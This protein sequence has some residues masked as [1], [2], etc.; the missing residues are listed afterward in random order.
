[1]SFSYAVLSGGKSVRMGQDKSLLVADGT[2]IIERIVNDIK[3]LPN[4]SD[5]LFMCAGETR[6]SQLDNENLSYLDDYLADYQG[7]LAG[8]AAVL[9]HLQSN[10]L[11]DCQW[12]YTFPTDTLLL[13]SQSFDLLNNAIQQ[14]PG[15]DMVYLR[16]ERDHPLHGA[17]NIGVAEKLFSYLDHGQR[18]VMQFIQQLNYQT[19]EIPHSWQ[20][21]LNFNTKHSFEKA[22]QAYKNDS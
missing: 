16:G 17:Y 6:Y 7:P 22:L 8:L 3:D 20:D 2:P 13:P 5:S 4:P 1:M 12:V 19:V 10:P 15:C 14:N 9:S 21:Y 18:A 11:S